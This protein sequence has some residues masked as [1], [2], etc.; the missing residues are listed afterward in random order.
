M[1]WQ[2]ELSGRH[3]SELAVPPLTRIA[4]VKRNTAFL[5]PLRTPR[6]IS[7][8]DCAEGIG[9][10]RTTFLSTWVPCASCVLMLTV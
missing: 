1:I 7:S 6:K 8:G 9:A 2:S 3:V 10:S 5:P 4:L